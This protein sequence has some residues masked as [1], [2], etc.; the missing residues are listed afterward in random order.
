MAVTHST[1]ADESFS[2]GGAAAWDAEHTLTGNVAGVDGVATNGIY[3][4]TGAGTAAART[5]PAA[6]DML[7]GK[8]TE[9]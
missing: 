4:R 7:L 8:L 3:V 2:E 9:N 6:V 1:Q 5:I